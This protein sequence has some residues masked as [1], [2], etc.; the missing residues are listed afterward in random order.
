MYAKVTDEDPTHEMTSSLDTLSVA[1]TNRKTAV[2]TFE[3]S[4][5]NVQVYLCLDD[6]ETLEKA[7]KLLK[8]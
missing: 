2:L 1:E 3:Q 6:V 5:F 4:I 8:G 7:I